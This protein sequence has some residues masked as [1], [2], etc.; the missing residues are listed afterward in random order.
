MTR[1]LS[2]RELPTQTAKAKQTAHGPCL[3]LSSQGGRVTHFPC[4][5][6]AIFARVGRPTRWLAGAYLVGV[7]LDG[8]GTT[9]PARI[10]PRT[11]SYFLQVAALFPTAARASIDYRAEAWVCA[12]RAWEE[13]DT[14]AYFPIQSDGKENRF[15]R[16]MHFFREDERTMHA[17][18]AYFVDGHRS[19]ARDDGIPFG[20]PIGGVRLSSLRIPIPQPGDV[21]ERFRRRP[22]S[23]YPQEDKHVFYHTP[24]STLAERCATGGGA[25]R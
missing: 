18:D 7:W 12:D 6:R 25:S 5:A 17:L 20:R 11:A 9:L 15:Q 14:R 8:T 2:P 3:A 4:L 19:A 16:V 23:D 21:I 13:L 10:L 24:R 1:P 22:L